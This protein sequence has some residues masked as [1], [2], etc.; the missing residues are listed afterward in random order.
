MTKKILLAMG[1]ASAMTGLSAQADDDYGSTSTF[2]DDR[3]Y[4]APF[5]SYLHTGGD[6]KGF[7]G[8]GAGG[9]VGKI[10]N[11]YFNVE[12]RGFWQGYGNSI[13]GGSNPNYAG[14]QTDLAGGTIDLQYYFMRDAFSPY[15]VLALGGMNTSARTGDNSPYHGKGKQ[16]SSFI[17]ELG[18]GATYE[19]TDNFLLRGDVRYRG[20]TANA[21]SGINPVNGDAMSQNTDLLS[22]MVVNLGFVIPLGEKP[23][24]VAEAPAAAPVD[25]CANRDTDHDGV[26]DCDDKCPG[27]MKGSKIDDQGCPIVME[28]RG[29]NFQF[30]SDELTPGAK[31][32]LDGAADQL[33]AFPEKRDIEVAGYASDEGRPDKRQYNLNLSQRRSESVVRYLK[34]KGVA[35]KLYAKGYGV[36]YPIA[37]NRTEAG[38]EKN[39]RVELRWMGD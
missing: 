13:G 31:R 22:D 7:D 2:M 12:V 1:L 4:I 14:G 20:N 19:L 38:R 21:L 28:L 26:N 37:D 16:Q 9:A 23:G 18:V 8:W 35:N 5:G 32:I 15:A 29:V 10:I 11:E 6:T 27:T 39:R 25:E 36:E 24:A 30:D 17:F 33:V 3:F 34:A